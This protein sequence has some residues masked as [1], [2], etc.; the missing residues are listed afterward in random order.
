[1]SCSFNVLAGLEVS[2]LVSQFPRLFI[3]CE[4]ACSVY[5]LLGVTVLQVVR[6]SQPSDWPPSLSPSP[7]YNG[8]LCAFVPHLF[9]RVLEGEDFII[10]SLCLLR[11]THL[12]FMKCERRNV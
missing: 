9:L 6:R 11:L 2:L 12:V 1:M 8:A 4:R 7:S 5:A 10:S 3:G